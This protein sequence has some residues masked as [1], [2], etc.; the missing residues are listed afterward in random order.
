MKIQHAIEIRNSRKNI[1]AFLHLT[2]IA[3]I[4]QILGE[5]IEKPV[6]WTNVCNQVLES[7]NAKKISAKT[8]KELFELLAESNTEIRTEMY[9]FEVDSLYQYDSHQRAYVYVKQCSKKEYN[10]FYAN[11]Y[12]D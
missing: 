3:K 4:E 9:R 5:D 8:L 2:D 6:T 10:L 7:R 1:T 12:F 11:V